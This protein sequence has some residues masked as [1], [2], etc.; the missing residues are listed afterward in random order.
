MK[1]C[2]ASIL[3]GLMIMSTLLAQTDSLSVGKLKYESAK[4]KIE[5]DALASYSNSLTTAMAPLKQ[6][7]DLDTFLTIQKELERIN[8][9]K[10]IDST[11][12]SSGLIHL[13]ATK[14]VTDRN[15]K[16][17]N[18]I[19][20]Y[21][22]YLEGLIKQAMLTNKIEDAKEI[23][24][25]LDKAKFLLADLES[26]LPNVEQPKKAEP[27]TASAPIKLP[28]VRISSRAKEYE[29]H[30][31]LVVKEIMSWEKA[32][33]ACEKAGGHL[34]TFSTKEENDFVKS[35]GGGDYW[36]GLT[37]LSGKWEW[38]DGS[39]VSYTD[40]GKSDIPAPYVRFGFGTGVWRWGT[41]MKKNAGYICEWDY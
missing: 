13:N 41:D 31:Y 3:A 20:Q 12:S 21:V 26:K 33:A 18:L 15:Q 25:E 11:N 36:I 16:L 24:T 34:V 7:G 10:T 19:K 38:V 29:K 6:K 32:K 14:C 17:Q 22:A 27:P 28:K 23:K 39:E 5:S 40:W 9:D 4:E 35:L 1:K 8:A 30:H 37:K 2:I